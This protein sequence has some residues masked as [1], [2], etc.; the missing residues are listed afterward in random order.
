MPSIRINGLRL[1]FRTD[2][3]PAKP[4][5]VL[6]N[7]LGT[8]LSMWDAQAASLVRDFHVLRYDTRGH[9]Q[10][11]SGFAPFSLATL[12]Y[13]VVGL[14][15]ALAIPR[16]HFCGISMG[17]MIGQWL[18]IHQPRRLGK[19]V[20]AN[21]SAR[22]GTAEGWS[23]R[24]DQ[25]RE[26]G[27]AGVA[28]GAAARWFTP[29]FIARAPQVVDRMI[30]RLRVQDTQGYA[31]CCDALA[32]ADLRDAVPGIGCAPLIIGGRA[33]PVTTMEDARWLV[34]QIAGASLAELDASHISNVEAEQAFS[35]H[36]LR[37]MHA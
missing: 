15:D 37:F 22:I 1:Y 2:G 18:G 17:G 3:D 26:G 28:D 5:V 10:S 27:I 34:D 21:T 24:A 11:E 8:D 19:L 32:R 25:V 29:D 12:G 36:L 14:L 13:D 6:S 33:D 9:G 16:A 20:L 7:S 23:G 30:G 4:C 35:E 31:A